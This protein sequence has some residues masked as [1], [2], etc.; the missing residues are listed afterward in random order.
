MHLT[1][2]F[3]N[4]LTNASK[5]S[6]PGEEI[7]ISVGSGAAGAAVRVSDRGEGIAPERLPKIFAPFAQS[8]GASR[9]GL[10]VGLP[11]ARRL[12]ELHGGTVEAASA[13]IG[14]GSTF[15]V[16]LPLASPAP[17][18]GAAESIAAPVEGPALSGCRVLVVDDNADAAQMLQLHLQTHGCEVRCTYDGASVLA[19]ARE[20]APEVLLLDL[21][22]PDIDGYEVLRRLRA[23][24]GGQ[25]AVIA[26]TG[27]AQPADLARMQ[28]AGFDRSLRKPVAAATLAAAIVSVWRKAR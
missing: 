21:A 14:K 28:E 26:L 17:P 18:G 22:L 27:F 19:L 25:A 7:R 5:Y 1:Q 20:F 3:T 6:A 2:I 11:L 8:G 15:T 23:D 10:G 12:A 4:L 13:G 16:T 9:T 24:G